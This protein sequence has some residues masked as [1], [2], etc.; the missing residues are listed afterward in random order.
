MALKRC[1]LLLTLAFLLICSCAHVL[2]AQSEDS[3]HEQFTN[4]TLRDRYG[5][6]TLALSVDLSSPTPTTGTGV[7]FAIS[8]FYRFNGDGTL[9]GHDW[10]SAADPTNPIVE[11]KYTGVYQVDSDGTG[12]LQLSFPTN[13]SFKPVGKF[14][15]VDSGRAIEIVFVVPGNMNTFELRKQSC[16]HEGDRG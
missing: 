3:D 4:A 15:I 12:T 9:T 16:A 11:R 7:P 14:T 1:V 10:V 8:G 13:P 6:H 2:Y 5:F